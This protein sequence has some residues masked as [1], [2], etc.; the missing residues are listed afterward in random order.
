MY[1]IYSLRR[2]MNRLIMDIFGRDQ[3]IKASLLLLVN[4]HFFVVFPHWLMASNDVQVE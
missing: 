1:Y 4:M 2:L 3:K